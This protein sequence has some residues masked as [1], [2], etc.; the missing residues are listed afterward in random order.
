MLF[1]INRNPLNRRTFARRT[2]CLILCSITCNIISYN[3]M[4]IVCA[5]A[6]T[7]ET[8][9]RVRYASCR[10]CRNRTIRKNGRKLYVPFEE[11]VQGG[12]TP[13]RYNFE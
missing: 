7:R 4:A 9:I 13:P 2:D 1:R 8:R 12:S 3:I 11:R 5:R 6:T 10:T